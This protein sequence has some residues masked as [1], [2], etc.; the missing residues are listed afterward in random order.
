VQSLEDRQRFG[1]LGGRY[2]IYSHGMK[3][4]LSYVSEDI[5]IVNEL[6]DKQVNQY[7][8]PV[9]DSLTHRCG[10]PDGTP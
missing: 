6:T 9:G 8:N 3:R 2:Y 10:K 1:G 7:L 5:L 4:F